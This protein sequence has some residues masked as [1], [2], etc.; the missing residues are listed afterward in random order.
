MSNEQMAEIMAMDDTE[1]Y[2]AL[3]IDQLEWREHG[4]A[5]AWDGT[6]GYGGD[7]D[8][9]VLE[10][11][12]ERNDDREHVRTELLWSHALGRWW[13]LH[14]GV[15]HDSGDGPS[16]TW[17]ALGIEGLAPYWLDVETSLYIGDAGRTALRL[18][19]SY[20][21]RLTQRCILQ[22]QI[23]VNAY[24]EDDPARALGSGLSD[25]EAGLRLRYELRREIAP[26]VGIQW[27][28]RFGGTAD[29][30]RASG[31]ATSDTQWVAGIRVWF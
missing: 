10:S 6:L 30:A 24:G 28:Q 3:R 29:L 5:V 20:E 4:D 15:R 22:P 26:Y 16:R 11:E 2:G 12:G 7:Y 17:A 23:E 1:R 14:T 9:V 19:A 18:A 8:K 31:A 13:N 25:M 27:T 21:L